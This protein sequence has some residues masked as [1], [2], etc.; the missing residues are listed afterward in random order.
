MQSLGLVG[1]KNDFDF[2]IMIKYFGLG[3]IFLI[4]QVKVNQSYF[5]LGL[6]PAQRKGKFA[7]LSYHH[8]GECHC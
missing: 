4:S 3:L 2:H 8:K 7:L 5:N 1:G 6:M